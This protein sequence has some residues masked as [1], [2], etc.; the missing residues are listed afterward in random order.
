MTPTDTQETPAESAQRAS[1][2][3]RAQQTLD[4]LFRSLPVGR[5]FVTGLVMAFKA[6]AAAGLAYA[7]GRALHTEQAFW[8]A[9]T[10]I[11][12]TQLH[13]N[14]SRGVA[15]DQCLGAAFGGMAGLLG[16]WIGGSGDVLSY[17]VALAVVTVACWTAN[18]GAAARL[19]GITATIVLLVPSNGP[20][21]QIA[22]YRLGEVALGTVCALLIG[23]LVSLVQERADRKAEQEDHA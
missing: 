9:I 20:S 11:G 22:L 10:A 12:V 18:A 2:L 23:W 1:R 3:R 16:L 6:I 15:R 8:A 21:W 17:V 5:R 19:G 13:F 7:I 14:D 4:D